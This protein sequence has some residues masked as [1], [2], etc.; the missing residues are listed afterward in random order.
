[1]SDQQIEGIEA[2]L[3]RGW[4]AVRDDEGRIWITGRDWAGF[5]GDALR[6]R[7]ASG[8]HFIEEVTP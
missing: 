8:L 2:Y 4:M 5:T 1:M 3:W 7:L 6:E